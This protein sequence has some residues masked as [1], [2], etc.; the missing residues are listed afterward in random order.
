MDGLYDAFY[1]FYED[2]R[3]LRLLQRGDSAVRLFLRRLQLRYHLPAQVGSLAP[4]LGESKETANEAE[5]PVATL[6]ANH[7]G[8][9]TQGLF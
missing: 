1:D 2:H 4:I 9:S 6:F 5:G 8:L 3:P 7:R